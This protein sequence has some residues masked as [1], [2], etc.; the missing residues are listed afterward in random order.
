MKRMIAV[1][2]FLGLMCAEHP[3]FAQSFLGPHTSNFDPL[4]M[5]YFNPAGMAN[6]EMRWQVN[7][8]SFDIRASNDFISLKGLKGIASGGEFDRNRFFQENFNGEPVNVQ[9]DVD[10][11]GPGFM[12]A[13]G[14][15]AISFSTRSRAIV[16][17][18]DLDETFASSL[19]NYEDRIIQYLPSFSDVRTTAG[20]NVYNEFSLGYARKIIDKDKHSLSAGVNV[21]LLNKVFYAGFT[22][23]G[24][25]FQKSY[26]VDDSLINVGSTQFEIAVSNDLEDDQFKYRWAIDGVA[27]D[28]GAEYTYGG[29]IGGKYRLKV[30]AAVNDFGVLK[31][32]YGSSSR[33]FVGNGRDVPVSSLID[34]EGEMRNFDEVLDSLGTRTT[35][36]GKMDIRL[37]SVMHLYADVRLVSQLYVF[38]GI[39]LNPFSFKNVDKLANLPT[40]LQIIPRFETK[41]IG[42][43]A[44]LSWDK[45]AGFS[46]G[47]GFRIGQFSVG[48][49]NIISS[50]LGKNFTA[51]DL[52]LSLSFGGKRRVD[53][54]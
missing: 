24:I 11:R 10:V 37:P 18:N 12:F 19:F 46:S 25:D 8:L 14:K 51:V 23:N 43:Y 33:F 39:Q 35:P 36:S 52:F 1:M 6:S 15:N 13:F 34:S 49:S 5:V 50:V 22:G 27:F 41:L 17:I 32:Q 47:A 48:S 26:S 4:K 53:K 20:A 21:K 9:A 7:I 44:P 42:V 54:I 3:A 40:R 28:F 31:Q 2:L 38:A 29:N 30:G 16:A 45:F